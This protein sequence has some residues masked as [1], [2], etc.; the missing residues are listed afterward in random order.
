MS[1]VDRES[2]AEFD[3]RLDE[4]AK[5]QAQDPNFSSEMIARTLMPTTSRFATGR[6]LTN[7][8]QDFSSKKSLNDR[9]KEA[10]LALAPHI[11][12]TEDDIE[13]MLVTDPELGYAAIN[14][15]RD[16]T[17]LLKRYDK[18]IKAAREKD[19]LH[20]QPDSPLKT[21]SELE[22]DDNERYRQLTI[23]DNLDTET[24]TLMGQLSYAGGAIVG[25]LEDPANAVSMLVAGG[26]VGVKFGAEFAA[27]TGKEAFKTGFKWAGYEGLVDTSR[28][29]AMNRP[30]YYDL[31][32]KALGEEWSWKQVGQ[33]FAV[34]T[35]ATT[36]FSALGLLAGRQLANSFRW[37]S[38]VTEEVPG[39]IPES[40]PR[41]VPPDDAGNGGGIVQDSGVV[42][43]EFVN[44]FEEVKPYMDPVEADV[45]QEVVDLAKTT[46]EHLSQ[47]QHGRNYQVAL[48]QVMKGED[49]NVPF[50][51]L[52]EP[53]TSSVV[54]ETAIEQPRIQETPPKP[55]ELIMQTYNEIKSKLDTMDDLETLP[56]TFDGSE[57]ASDISVGSLKQRLK[58]HF[59]DADAIDKVITCWSK[60]GPSGGK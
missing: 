32:E 29:F 43:R 7:M 19:P 26:A 15:R 22:E 54:P 42:T 51:A 35:A 48:E 28:D 11:G 8:D 31:R 46:P 34:Q 12:K 36:T 47:P 2:L 27:A 60:G 9:S 13:M 16:Y 58:E 39:A 53:S 57:V 20:F 10:L 30:H 33:D 55:D 5:L 17:T 49:V 18:E 37:G 25:Y 50:R 40:G 21:Y 1:L 23:E 56:D 45:V 6:A 59:D 41:Y 4:Q 24:S 52:D 44:K 38:S 14:S 3:A